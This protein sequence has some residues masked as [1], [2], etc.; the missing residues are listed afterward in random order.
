MMVSAYTPQDTGMREKVIKFNEE[1]WGK[2]NVAYIDTLMDPD[3]I[4][5]GYTEQGNTA[6][7]AAFKQK[8]QEIRSQFTDYS[9]TLTDMMGVG[10]KATFTWQL[11]GNYVGP[12]QKISPGRP[13]DLMG[14]TV[15]T[16]Q[17][18]KVI[19]EVVEV[20]AEE[21]Y[22]QIQM[23]LPYSEIENRA[24]ALSYTYEVLSKGNVSSLSELVAEAHVLHDMNNQTIKGLDGLRNHVLDL[25]K[26]F[27]DVSIAINDVVADGNLVTT[28]WTITGTQRGAWNGIPATGKQFK[29]TGMTFMRM[30]NG[31]IQETWSVWDTILLGGAVVKN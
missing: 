3:F 20:D 4:R 5:L 27:P 15:W 17:G 28:R 6:G 11:R 19:S 8:V 7:I 9:L 16:F 26:A 14:K 21:Y 24:L 12:G 30:G 18:D 22:R 1:V 2:G 23:A 10:N 29:A 13:V 25:R 31:K